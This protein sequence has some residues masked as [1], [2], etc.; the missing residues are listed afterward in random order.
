MERL[1]KTQAKVIEAARDLTDDQVAALA[2]AFAD[3]IGERTEIM[4]VATRRCQELGCDPSVVYHA[5]GRMFK[6]VPDTGVGQHASNA[7]YC[8]FLA[9]ALIIMGGQTPDEQSLLTGP[10][11][12]ATGISLPELLA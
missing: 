11:L 10:W 6:G 12:A 8:T 9:L 1:S 5:M 4:E 3:R 7:V 2:K